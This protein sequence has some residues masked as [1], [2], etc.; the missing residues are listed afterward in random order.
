[1]A[2]ISNLEA[3]FLQKHSK[4]RWLYLA[5]ILQRILEQLPNLR[6]YFEDFLPK[7]TEFKTAMKT[8]S[9]KRRYER[10]ISIIKDTRTKSFLLFIIELI[11]EVFE[12]FLVKFQ[13]KESLIHIMYDGLGDL[14]FKL[15]S[16]VYDVDDLIASQSRKSMDDLLDLNTEKLTELDMVDKSQQAMKNFEKLKSAIVLDLEEVFRK[17][18]EVA[19]EHLR[20]KL[21]RNNDF[22]KNVTCINPHKLIARDTKSVVLLA[23]IVIRNIIRDITTVQQIFGVDSSTN[24]DSIIDMI[25]RQYT[26][27]CIEQKPVAGQSAV[28]FWQEAANII[29]DTDDGPKYKQV[30]ILAKICLTVNHANSIPE[31]GFSFNQYIVTDGRAQLNNE[32]IV[33]IRLIHDY[34]AQFDK[35]TDFP[36][37]PELI[38]SVQ[39]SYSKYKEYMENVEREEKDK[40]AQIE[41]KKIREKQSQAAKLKANEI[42]ELQLKIKVSE[43]LISE[44]N[45]ELQK[46]AKTSAGKTT[47][48]QSAM[49]FR[50]KV[51]QA[52]EKIEAALK[53]KKE[54][55][56]LLQTIN[57]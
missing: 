13:T 30:C 44:G 36:I 18:I 41:K 45:R 29:S 27:L 7:Q 37:T 4:T 25:K 57:V 52:S 40:K 2:E 6:L 48:P 24:R 31:R 16:K 53:R 17:S 23:E 21:P 55:E 15:M 38:K 1:M 56:D 46:A 28:S 39:N 35:I 9:Q 19:I 32:T 14:T 33:S 49:K 10:I 34:Q 43:D 12:P 54:L 42:R 50:K 11:T 47:D 20:V 51:M 8:D 3:Q 5:P 26:I 22:L